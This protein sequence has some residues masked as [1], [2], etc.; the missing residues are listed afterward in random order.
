MNDELRDKYPHL[1]KFVPYLELLRKES[2][3]GKVLISTGFLEQQL[4]DI[5]AAF[6]RDGAKTASL[7]DGPNAPLGAFSSRISACHAFGLI[8][9]R[10]HHDLNVLRRIRNDFAHDMHT[11]FATPSVIDRCR[12]L[13]MKASDYDSETRG[14]VRVSPAGQFQTAA[15]SLIVNLT[16]RPHYVAKRRCAA[17]EW[18]Y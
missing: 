5:L 2:D 13:Q 11:S 18:P 14:E 8:S 6:M 15:V 4:R 1:D 10:E 9:N 7:L 12:T 16:N 3:R 17:V